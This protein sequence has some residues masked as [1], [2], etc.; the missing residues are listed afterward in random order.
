MVY[1]L[2]SLGCKNCYG[3]DISEEQVNLAKS[4]GIKNIIKDNF[5]NFLKK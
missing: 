3:I 1:W 4:L 2:Q 5:I